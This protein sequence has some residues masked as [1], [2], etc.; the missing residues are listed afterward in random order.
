MRPILNIKK[1][2][3]RYHNLRLR[4]MVGGGPVFHNSTL[5]LLTFIRFC[6]VAEFLWLS[7]FGNP[8][9]IFPLK[10]YLL[11]REKFEKWGGRIFGEPIISCKWLNK[12]G[13]YFRL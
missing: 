8:P 10:S 1:M 13:M 7:S 2:A 6:A 9:S 3:E 11:A 12:V 5:Y 4:V